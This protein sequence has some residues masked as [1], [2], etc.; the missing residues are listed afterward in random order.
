MMLTTIFLSAIKQKIDR[1]TIALADI[2]Q[3]NVLMTVGVQ[4]R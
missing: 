1:A 2:H 3:S 4:G